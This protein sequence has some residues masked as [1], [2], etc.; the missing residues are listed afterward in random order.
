MRTY[1]CGLVAAGLMLVLFAARCQGDGLTSEVREHRG[2][3]ALY[4]NGVLTSQMLAAPY[5]DPQ[6]NGIADFN[7]FRQ[8]GISIFDIYVRFPWTAPETYDFAPVDQ[9]LDAYLAIDNKILFLPRVLLTPGPWFRTQFPDEISMRD[10]GSPAGMFPSQNAGNNPSFSSE[11]YRELSHKAMIAFIN[12]LESKY[13][14]HIVGYQVGNGFGGEWLPFNSFWETRPGESPPTK[15]GVEDYSPPA[16]AAF[17]EWLTDKYKTDA[18]LQAAWHDPKVTLDTVIPPNEVER[19]TTTRGIFFDPAVSARCPDWF[20]FYNESV[21]DVLIDNARWV[22]ELTGRKK[23]VGSFYGY[24]WC[25]FPN[26]SA[27]HSGQL[28]LTKVLNCPDVDFVCSPYTYDNKGIGGP[29]NSQTLPEAAT[30]HGKLYFNE[31][32][33]ETHLKQRQWRWG[34]SLHNPTNFAET[35][36]LLVRDYAYSLTKG[37]GLWWTDLMGGDYHDD[38]IIKLLGQLKRIDEQQ[39]EADKRSTTDI[40]VIMDESAFTYTG[41]GEPLWNALL[42]AQKQWEFAFIGAPWEPQLLNDIDNPKLRDY[43]LYIF[44]NTFHVT[45]KQRDA[46]HAKLKKNNATALWIYAPGYIDGEKCSVDNM[47]VLTGI[48]LAEDMTP[49]ELHVAYKL[50]SPSGAAF[51]IY[52]PGTAPT[53]MSK[54]SPVT[55]IIRFI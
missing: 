25:N 54:R 33:T 27:V 3:P 48:K 23:I 22:K 43:K 17:K 20:S 1:L 47:A 32:D 45:P 5:R 28:G 9:K 8:A 50:R 15:F 6:R 38:E 26:L 53:S 51:L 39:L 35:K 2:I 34:D 46:I 49:G 41:D 7:D 19:Y 30:L 42:T 11:K 52:R 36:G 13:G 12:H 44:L 21:A 40:A 14:D 55:T 37:N 18:V 24:L 31:V 10:D 16:R 29:N 4:V